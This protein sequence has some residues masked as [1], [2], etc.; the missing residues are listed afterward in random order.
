MNNL[1]NE[2][3]DQQDQD[4]ID[5]IYAAQVAGDITLLEDEHIQF[6]KR[7]LEMVTVPSMKPNIINCIQSNVLLDS[8]LC[9]MG[10]TEQMY[11]I[12]N[13]LMGVI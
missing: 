1:L 8:Q 9:T 13:I 3:D 6:I 2:Y 12:V 5:G 4:I 10:L 7:K 11:V